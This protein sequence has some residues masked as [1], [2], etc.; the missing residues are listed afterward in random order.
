[1]SSTQ[2]TYEEAS[3]RLLE[4]VTKIARGYLKEFSPEKV[5]LSTRDCQGAV[6]VVA[7]VCDSP[8]EFVG[9]WIGYVEGLWFAEENGYPLEDHIPHINVTKD[10][11][12]L[13]LTSLG[14]LVS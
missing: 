9:I 12:D 2:E 3:K 7:E 14:R 8:H 6:I 11:A 13:I 1:M 4:R 10:F 5:K